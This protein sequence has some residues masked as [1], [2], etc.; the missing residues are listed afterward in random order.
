MLFQTFLLLPDL[1]YSRFPVA[2]NAGVFIIFG[3][4]SASLRYKISPSSSAKRPY[5][6]HAQAQHLTFLVP[7]QTQYKVDWIK[8]YPIFPVQS[9]LLN[10]LIENQFVLAGAVHFSSLS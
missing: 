7:H 3:K 2:I 4:F 9:A 8:R 6:V 5:A 1:V 10:H